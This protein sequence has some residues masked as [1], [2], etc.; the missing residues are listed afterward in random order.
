[1]GFFQ[2]PEPTDDD[3][4]AEDDDD[5]FD[6]PTAHW[7]GGVV[8]VEVVVARSDKAAVVVRGIVAYPD[9]FAFTLESFLHRSVRRR[10][11]GHRP[12]P[13]F[14]QWSDEDETIGD[15]MLRFGVSWPDGGRATN[16][17]Y[18]GPGWPDATEPAHGLEEGSGGGSDRHY[19]WEYWAWP[20]PTDGEL[21]FVC[22]W[23]AYGIPESF[24]PVDA[25]V[26]VEAATR[27]FPV[28]P[29]DAGRASHLTR[30]AM[31]RAVRAHQVDD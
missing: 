31:F 20:L 19:S 6:D 24:A 26:F 13:V 25:T 17:D 7:V 10:R 3:R 4:F 28:W 21:Q 11:R 2:L 29:D 22:E 18:W 15:E 1:M 12:F 16:L 14:G 27:A 8:P 5:E 30:S 9:G 23:P